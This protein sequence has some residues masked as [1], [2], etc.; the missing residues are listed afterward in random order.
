MD[1][2]ALSL[3]LLTPFVAA[4]INIFLWK[5]LRGQWIVYATASLL[6]LACS[7]WLLYMVAREEVIIMRVG[8]LEAP[9]AITLVCDMFSA[10]MLCA[11]AL[12]ALLLSFYVN[13]DV[14]LSREEMRY[15]FFIFVLFMFFGINGCLLTGDIFNLYV[16][17]EVI[18]LSSFALL[19]LGGRREQLEG[20]IKY[21]T[22]NFV[23]SALL[24]AGIGVV[25]GYVGSTN[26]AQLSLLMREK[27]QTPLVMISGMFFL[28]SLG[29]KSAVFPLFFWLPAS[30]HTPSISVTALIG[31]LITKVGMYT[32]IRIFTTI[33]P[34]EGSFIQYL[35]LVLSAL[36]MLTGVLGAVA[37]YEMRKLL[38]FHIISQIGYMVMGLAINTPLALGGAIFFILHN[39]IVKSN[40]FFISGLIFRQEGTN[41]LKQLG[42][43]YH[44]YSLLSFIFFFTAFSLA[45]VPPLS[46]FWGK[47]YLV[48][49]GLNASFYIVVGISLFTGLL[50][51]FSMA[52]IWRYAF[53]R[54]Q[55]EQRTEREHSLSAQKR[56]AYGMYVS[57]IALGIVI[58]CMSFYPEPLVRLSKIA[59]QQLYDRK[60]YVEKVL[61]QQAYDKMD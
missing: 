52:K 29:I 16:W 7:A 42:G 25:Y 22:I 33:I 35:L 38:S 26:M 21:V 32:L 24:L 54:K 19:T 28:V 44:N 18:L 46:G 15:G 47:Y 31:G 5:K 57:M 59:G 36:T 20:A 58:L 8:G 53:L 56:P 60:V 9:F 43:Y 34:F 12:M 48:L 41:Q 30:Y 39:I 10:L 4:I 2:F 61:N 27:G 23:A 49:A 17:F 3:P 40:L 6:M 11:T 37:Q 14:S 45:G 13:N 55:P 50:T 1:K 51:L